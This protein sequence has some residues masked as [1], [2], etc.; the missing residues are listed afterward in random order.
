MLDPRQVGPIIDYLQNQKFVG[1]EVEGAPGEWQREPPPQPGLSMQGRTVTTLL[2]QVEDW[3]SALGRLRNLPNAPYQRPAF[4]GFSAERQ[5]PKGTVRWKIRQLLNARDLQMESEALS[6]CVSSY[7]W[8]CAD[9]DCTIW[10]LSAEFGPQKIER[11]QTIE[12]DQNR[13]IIQ[14]RGLAN[15]D[16]TSE[17]WAIVKAWAKEANLGLSNY[18]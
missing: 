2:R 15:R 16:A 11:R 14:C 17:E 13:T 18:F 6:H 7:H 12:V 5:G 10:S 1:H 8:S 9:G 3:H 4:D